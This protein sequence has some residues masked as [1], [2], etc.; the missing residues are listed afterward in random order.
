MVHRARREGQGLG[1]GEADPVRSLTGWAVDPLNKAP[2]LRPKIERF[3][4]DEA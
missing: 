4:Q 1:G 3:Q 2:V